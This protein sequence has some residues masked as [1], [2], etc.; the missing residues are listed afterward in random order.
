[1]GEN[2]AEIEVE[3]IVLDGANDGWCADA[4]VF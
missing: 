2:G 1:M 3:V 4:E